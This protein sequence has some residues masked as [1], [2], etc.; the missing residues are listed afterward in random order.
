MSAGR[1]TGLCQRRIPT[2]A[3]NRLLLENVAMLG[4][5]WSDYRYHGLELLRAAYG[6]LT[7][8]AGPA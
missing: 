6:R 8:F 4:L 5:Y 7:S 2:V 1:A 3:A